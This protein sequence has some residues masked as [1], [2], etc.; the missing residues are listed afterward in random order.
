[1]NARS[2]PV[3]LKS[4]AMLVAVAV[5]WAEAPKPAPYFE[6]D[7]AASDPL[8]VEQAREYDRYIADLLADQP[9][10]RQLLAPD[11]SS[12]EAY[13]ESLAAYR[14]AFARSMSFP[15]P[16]AVPAGEPR[17]ERL[18]EDTLGVYHRVTIPVRPGLHVQG[19]YLVPKGAGG[20]RPFVL[21]VHGGAGSPERALF[22]GGANYHDMV[23]GA[24][25]RGYVVFAPQLLFSSPG[26]PPENR[27]ETDR[28]LR[29]VGTSISAVEIAK[30]QRALDILLAR[31]EV[32]ANRVAAVGL[33]YGGYY[34]LVTAALEPRIKVVV[35]SCYFGV[36]EGRFA[37]D[38]MSVPTDLDFPGRF[39]LFRDSDLVAL[40]CPRPLLI[41]AGA[42]D[43][44]DHR[45]P[46]R[47]LAPVSAAYYERLGR[48]E[49]FR[50]LVFEGGHEFDDES[51]WAWVE[52]HL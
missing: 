42:N 52:R 6:Q 9:E 51:A 37:R 4:G 30:L 28:R 17:F 16:G 14:A 45:E 3:M 20:P 18:G 38:P 39:S 23:R 8:R 2:F 47:E 48:S 32:D 35:S 31:P 40:I 36:Q 7:I 24:L 41:Q 21:A 12:K 50:H 10:R 5:G 26:L 22:H 43:S 15:P 44:V 11:F 33:S 19:L 34:V 1:M 49:A 29:Q 13:S 27:R 25:K 46:G